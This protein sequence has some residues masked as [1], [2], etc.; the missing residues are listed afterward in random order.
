MWIVLRIDT[1]YTV[2]FITVPGD[3]K[4]FTV[5]NSPLASFFDQDTRVLYFNI[6]ILDDFFFEPTEQFS[7]SLTLVDDFPVQIIPNVSV[8]TILDDERKCTNCW[9]YVLVQN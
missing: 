6:T 9:S 2:F 4:S 5:F 3:Y 1:M 7:I 8:I